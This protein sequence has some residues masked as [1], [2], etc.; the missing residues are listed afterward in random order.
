M[1]QRALSTATRIVVTTSTFPRWAGDATPRFVLDLCRGIQAQGT[2]VCTVLAPHAAGSPRREKLEGV[3]VRRY[4]YTPPGRLGQLSGGGIMPVLRRR[5]HLLPQAIALVACQFVA[6]RTLLAETGAH[7]VLA[8]WLVPQG[9]VAVLLKKLRPDITVIVVVHGGDIGLLRSKAVYRRL[10]RYIAQRCDAVFAVCQRLA[11]EVSRVTPL[12]AAKTVTMPLG[13]DAESILRDES[14]RRLVAAS[15]G[16]DRVLWLLHAHREMRRLGVDVDLRIVGGGTLQRQA[17]R[18]CRESGLHDSVQ[19]LG[20]CDHRTVIREMQAARVFVAP[21]V[22]TQSD[23]DGV[24]ITILEAALCG[25]PVVTTAA[26]G[27]AEFIQDGQ[28]G[29]IVAQG[30]VAALSA[31]VAEMLRDRG[32]ACRLGQAA[33]AAVLQQ[34]SLRVRGPRWE[35]AIRAAAR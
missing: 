15:H 12:A 22:D 9:L 21:H 19:F 30:D 16:R 26:G 31:A 11:D 33:R 25:L 29:I 35:Q 13:I 3:S 2:M 28:N 34:Y 20:T 14:E 7:V 24:P 5:K 8:N 23:L 10:L 32:R 4:R 1:D 18:F 6:L 17:R 27:I